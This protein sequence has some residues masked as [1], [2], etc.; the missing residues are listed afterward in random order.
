MFKLFLFI[1]SFFLVFL[2]KI[3]KNPDVK[4]NK[5]LVATLLFVFAF[6][7]GIMYK[8]LLGYNKD[9]SKKSH[10]KKTKHIL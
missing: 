9:I 2:I 4:K 10:F 6:F 8:L 5:V 7:A 1:I 3:F